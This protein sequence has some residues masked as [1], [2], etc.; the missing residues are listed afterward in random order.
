[1]DNHLANRNKLGMTKTKMR[2]IGKVR[3]TMNGIVIVETINIKT[4]VKMG[5]DRQ[6]KV[7]C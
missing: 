3:A 2:R 5:R 4:L 6:T 7:V 1:M